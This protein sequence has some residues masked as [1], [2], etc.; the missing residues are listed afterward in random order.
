MCPHGY[1]HSGSMATSALG[2]RAF[3]FIYI[4]IMP[5]HLTDYSFN[6]YT[7]V[8]GNLI[9]KRTCAYVQEYPSDVVM[10]TF[11]LYPDMDTGT[12]EFNTVS[13][14]SKT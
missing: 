2:T 8:R 3:T 5:F 13:G 14:Y 4:R 6:N 9:L 1:H 7:N 12:F 11:Q 10:D